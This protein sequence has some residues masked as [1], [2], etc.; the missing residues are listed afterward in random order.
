MPEQDRKRRLCV[1]CYQ[2]IH[3]QAKVC[4]HCNSTQRVGAAERIAQ[5]LKW[6]GG[7]TVITSLVLGVFDLRK[8]VS[9]ISERRQTIS[10]LVSAAEGQIADGDVVTAQKLI[11][12][13]SALDPANPD[14]L[15][16][17]TI[18]AMDTVR[19]FHSPYDEGV[20]EAIE[21]VLSTLLIGA[22]SDDLQLSADVLAHVGWA[23]FLR[24][25]TMDYGGKGFPV[26]IYFR[27]SIEKDPENPF[28]HIMWSWVCLYGVFWEECENPLETATKHY[29][30]A[31]RSGRENDYVKELWRGA[32]SN[33]PVP[34]A[35]LE[36]VVLL[37]DYQKNNTKLE[38]DEKMYYLKYID[39]NV[40]REEEG[41]N[42]LLDRL[43]DKS[44]AGL[45]EWLGRKEAGIEEDDRDEAIRE[46]YTG[47]YLSWID[48]EK[49]RS[50]RALQ[51]LRAL[52]AK[53][54][55][56]DWSYQPFQI[57]RMIA[58]ILK[59]RRGW[60]G[61]DT[62]PLDRERMTQL[63]IP[64]PV[65]LLI[66]KVSADS[67]AEQAGVEV[68]DIIIAIGDAPLPEGWVPSLIGVALAG[69]EV[70]LGIWRGGGAIELVAKLGEAPG[71]ESFSWMDAKLV[72]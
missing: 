15:K 42:R 72:H 18:L 49:G 27:R 25:I 24:P 11:D 36:Y 10:Q 47:Y 31:N 8:I 45:L 29:E 12:Q 1:N 44:C 43:G 67:P 33:S 9:Q 61:I 30:I 55:H 5:V 71:A 69:D 28:A 17:K 16:A 41:F 32:L 58:Q 56:Y 7:A 38:S 20:T 52:R 57:D 51:R 26:Q 46:W 64:S 37:S 4:H 13:A 70:R 22:N 21:P 2:A 48:Y 19:Q 66:A 6:I 14:T 54:L 3:P 63:K 34:G 60:L 50:D 68:G 35:W 62:E 23:N 39:E 59:V 53:I 65:G 40:N